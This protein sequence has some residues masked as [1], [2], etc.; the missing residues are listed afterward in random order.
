MVRA[1]EN[2]TPLL[3][4]V[5]ASDPNTEI[6]TSGATPNMPNSSHIVHASAS[7]AGTTSMLVGDANQP[8]AHSSPSLPPLTSDSADANEGDGRPASIDDI[9]DDVCKAKG[10]YVVNSCTLKFLVVMARGLT[11]EHYEPIYDEDDEPWNS[12]PK[13]Q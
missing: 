5:T 7:S 4:N 10:H 12:I 6:A 3:K 11:D 8:L 2:Q 9:P 13:N 1:I